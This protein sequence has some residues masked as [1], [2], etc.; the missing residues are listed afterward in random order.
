MLNVNSRIWARIKNSLIWGTGMLSISFGASLLLRTLETRAGNPSFTTLSDIALWWAQTITGLG[1][2]RDLITEEAKLIA[3]FIVFS[4]FIL[5][6]LFISDFSEIIRMFYARR[7]E[8]NIRISYKNHVLIF[9]YTA[10]TAGVI[11]LLKEN[12]GSGIKIVLVS[13]EIEKNPFPGQ[14]DFMHDNPIDT[15]TFIDANAA[16]AAAAIILANDR[17]RDPDGYSLVIASRVEKLNSNVIT[18]VELA[19]AENKELFKKAKVEA[20]ISKQE[21]L[22][23]LIGGN[24][25]SKL[26]RVLAKE[27]DYGR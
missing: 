1:A 8:G 2:P 3:I 24:S 26:M 25:D 19:G 27:S 15:A 10:A 20:L 4:G 12:F 22:A 17:F 13:N 16:G 9:G 6:G 7:E 23:D 5:L 21:L 14:V 18:V 11:N